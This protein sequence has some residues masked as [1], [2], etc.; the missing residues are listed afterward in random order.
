ME[1]EASKRRTL[2]RHGDTLGWW[3][4]E[5]E[6]APGHTDRHGREYKGV[7]YTILRTG[8]AYQNSAGKPLPARDRE[9]VLLADEVLGY[10][11]RAGDERDQADRIAFREGLLPPG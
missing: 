11:L 10:I 2:L 3:A 6:N 9:R 5:S 4:Y 8:P 7:T 1:T